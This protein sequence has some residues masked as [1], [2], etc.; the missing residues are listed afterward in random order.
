MR[1]AAVVFALM[2]GFADTALA[3]DFSFRPFFMFSEQRFA[4]TTTFEATLGQTTQP[5]WGGGLNVTQDDRFYLE[6]SASRFEKTG[7]RAFVNNG[8]PFQLN[9]PLTVSVTPL[10]FSFGYRFHPSAQLRPYV[11][12]GVG[13]YHYKETSQFSTDQ[14]NVDTNHAGVIV[15]GGIEFRL[16]RWIGVAADAHYTYVPGILGEGGISKDVNEKSLGGIAARFKVIVG[17]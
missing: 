1:G 12:G 10:E 17:K 16:H 8:Q 6:A 5:F 9:I 14:E 15:E 13:I 2:L 3:Q 11:G 4:A 7:T